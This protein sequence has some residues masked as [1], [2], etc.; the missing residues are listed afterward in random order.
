MIPLVLDTQ[1]FLCQQIFAGDAFSGAVATRT[2]FHNGFFRFEHDQRQF[3]VSYWTPVDAL[4]ELIANQPATTASTTANLQPATA[5]SSSAGLHAADTAA[6]DAPATVKLLDVSGQELPLPADT[7]S[8]A[9]GNAL[10]DSNTVF[11]QFNDPQQPPVRLELDGNVGDL[12]QWE[13]TVN[14]PKNFEE[15]VRRRKRD[16]RVLRPAHD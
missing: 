12:K 6:S 14:P 15:Q 5:A 16:L 10:A 2:Q 8:P 1:R 4:A 13:A 3:V 9:I 7:T 11:I